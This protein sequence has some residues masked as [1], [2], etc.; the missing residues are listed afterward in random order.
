M[1]IKTAEFVISN[2]DVKKCPIP[3]FPEYAFIGRSNV[4]K[5]S[6]I[7]MLTNNS[8]LAKISS[9]PGKTQL[10]NHFIINGNWY[11]VDLP[12]YGYAKVSK[13][14]RE[15]WSK[16]LSKYIL[17][18]EN[19]MCLFVLIDSRLEPQLIDL[20]LMEQLGL[21]H[22][23]FIILFTKIDK[24]SKNELMENI[25]KMRETMLKIWDEMPQFIITSSKTNKGREK[26]LSYIE[27]LNNKFHEEI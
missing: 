16:F 15:A 17:T 22:I 11:L 7:N 10:I 2:T 21:N 4:G 12:G 26:I 24:I 25:T 3:K 5:S 19:L 13:K 14:K 27:D 18:R 8:N 23:P 1:I 20:E 6:L 9:S